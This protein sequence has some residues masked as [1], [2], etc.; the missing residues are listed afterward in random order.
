MIQGRF[1]LHELLRQYLAEKLDEDPGERIKSKD[2]HLAYFANFL[3]ERSGDLQGNDPK[4]ALADIDLEIEN[5]R[6]AWNWALDQRNLEAIERSLEG[7]A[8]F[9]ILCARYLEGE[10]AFAQGQ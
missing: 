2:K 9:Y 6:A 3:Q 5:I 1:I 8:K 10:N 7:L 4:Q